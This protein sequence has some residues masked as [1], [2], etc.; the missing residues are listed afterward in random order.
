MSF[1]KELVDK[2]KGSLKP[3]VMKVRHKDGSVHEERISAQGVEVVGSKV[4]DSG[5][6]VESSLSSLV[7]QLNVNQFDVGKGK[8]VARPKEVDLS[9]EEEKFQEVTSFSIVTY[10]VWFDNSYKQERA[11]ALLALIESLTPTVDV[12]CFQ[13]VTVGFLEIVKQ[14]EWIR[15]SFYL[16][17]IGD[18]SINPYGVIIGSRFPP[19]KFEMHELPTQMGRKLVKMFVKIG[20]VDMEIATVHLESLGNAQ[21]RIQQLNIIWRTFESTKDALFMGDTNIYDGHVECKS[22]DPSFTDLWPK[23][24]PDSSAEAGSTMASI[25]GVERIDRIFAK[26]ES[27]KADQIQTIGKEGIGEGDLSTITPSDHL[28]LYATFSKTQ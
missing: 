23:L 7:R 8:W 2:D 17:E 22:F 10:N 28:G 24:N 5:P 9:S 20:G 4:V 13:E 12:F 21:T 3:T 16:S 11:A 6:S 26:L 1:L 27:W 19:A 15:N 14:L 25:R 18:R